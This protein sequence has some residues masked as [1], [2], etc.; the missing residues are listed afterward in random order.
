M[1]IKMGGVQPIVPRGQP[2]L[3]TRNRM[4]GTRPTA[5]QSSRHYRPDALQGSRWGMDEYF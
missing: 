3:P 4:M 2:H 1:T 5:G